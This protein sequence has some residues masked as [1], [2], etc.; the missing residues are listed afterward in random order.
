[1]CQVLLRQKKIEFL[2]QTQ[3]FTLISLQKLCLWAAENERRTTL[4]FGR[5]TNDVTINYYFFRPHHF[6][7]W[8][9]EAQFNT[10]RNIPHFSSGPHIF[11]VRTT[12]IFRPDHT[13]VSSRPHIFFIWNSH[14]FRPDHTHICYF[15][16]LLLNWRFYVIVAGF[17]ESTTKNLHILASGF[18]LLEVLWKEMSMNCFI[19]C[20]YLYTYVPL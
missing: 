11:F 18:D 7:V 8:D 16:I 15:L 6:F 2:A 9:I 20:L 4:F 13:Y 19:N 12:Y 10:K 5:T 1:M 3:I 14:N 17:L